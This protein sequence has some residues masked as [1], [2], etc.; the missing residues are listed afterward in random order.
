MLLSWVHS[1]FIQTPLRSLYFKGPDGM[2]FWGGAEVTDICASLTTTSAAFWSQHYGECVDVCEKRFQAFST[3]VNFVLYIL[4]LFRVVNALAFHFC[5]TRPVMS[6]LRAL[7][8]D[9]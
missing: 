5:F 6:E 3:S 7:L 4:I 2:G 1:F 8:G 9:K